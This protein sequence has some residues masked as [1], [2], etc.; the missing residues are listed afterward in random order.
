MVLERLRHWLFDER[1]NDALVDVWSGVHLM[2]GVAMGWVMDP[3]VA[4]LLLVLWEPFEVLVLS[5]LAERM[6]N[7]EFGFEGLR[8]VVSDILFDALGV[9][10][11]FWVLRHFVD[12]PFVW[13]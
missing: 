4:L 3:F 11:G 1:R 12:P 5:P 10:L 2:T 9:A 13:F 7:A 6:W 8:N